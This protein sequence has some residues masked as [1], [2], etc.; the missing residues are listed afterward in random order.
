MRKKLLLL[1][2][3]LTLA[4]VAGL[5]AWQTMRRGPDNLMGIPDDPDEVIL[6]S[7]DGTNTDEEP[8]EQGRP[9]GE[10]LL[11][12]YPILGRVIVTDPSQ[13][14]LVIALVKQDIQIGWP[15]QAKC[16]Y[17]RHVLRVV[18]AGR[19]IDVVICFECHKC[20]IHQ[21]GDSD[22]GL[23]QTF[24]ERSLTLLNKIIRD[25]GVP[26]AR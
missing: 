12:E 8:E 10:E 20:E 6:F 25:A 2:A 18:K 9:K 19:I 14:Q 13:K 21:N 11:Y 5:C 1:G 3:I 7:V 4:G 15:V 23:T 26:I 22:G 16:F 17:P 24:G